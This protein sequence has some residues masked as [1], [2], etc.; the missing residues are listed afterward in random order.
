MN[1]D[2]FITSTFGGQ[3]AS[4]I[5]C[6]LCNHVVRSFDPWLSFQLAIRSSGVQT[7][8]NALDEYMKLEDLGDYKC[9]SCH[10]N[11][12]C[13]RKIQISRCPDI[14]IIQLKRAQGTSIKTQ[15]VVNFPLDGLDMAPYFID[16]PVGSSQNGRRVTPPF[17]YTCYAVI[18]HSGSSVTSGH[19]WSL[20]R[21][22]RDAQKWWKL[23]DRQPVIEIPSTRT[24]V[25]ESYILFYSRVL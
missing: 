4:I 13:K 9:D 21:D 2:S 5:T 22:R 8:R 11:G 10:R 3:L 24:Q 25:R 16:V 7:L 12:S 6:G 1:N 18:Q 23:E 17:K 15:T 20:V 14:L 19:Y